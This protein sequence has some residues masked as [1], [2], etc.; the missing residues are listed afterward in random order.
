MECVGCMEFALSTRDSRKAS[1]N[2]IFETVRK[3]R[4]ET[5]S[6]KQFRDCEVEAEIQEIVSWK[7]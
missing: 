5:V 4:S 6:W 3:Q 2:Q 7:Q 1:C